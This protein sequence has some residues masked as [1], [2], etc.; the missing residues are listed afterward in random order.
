MIRI[1]KVLIAGVVGLSL[2]TMFVQPASAA[3]LGGVDVLSYCKSQFGAKS[4]VGTRVNAGD[5]YSWRC[6]YLGL[7]LIYGMNM[8]RACQYNFAN[9]RAYAVLGDRRNAYSWSCR[10]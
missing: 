1:P 6:T 8:S 5:A 2:A 4:L 9:A 3:T 10:V 7:P